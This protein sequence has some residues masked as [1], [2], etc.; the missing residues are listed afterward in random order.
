MTGSSAQWTAWRKIRDRVVDA[1]KGNTDDSLAR[2]VSR[3][4]TQNQME[5][6]AEY[7]AG[8]LAGHRYSAEVTAYY[9]SL[10]GPPTGGGK[11]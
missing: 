9:K 3:Y 11:K 1:T 2:K 8:R 7:F 6:V 10:F 5:F 4:A